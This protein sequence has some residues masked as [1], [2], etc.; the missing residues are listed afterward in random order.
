VVTEGHSAEALDR[1][2]YDMLSG[3]KVVEVSMWAFVPSAGAVL[4]D[5]GADVVKVVPVDLQDPMLGKGVVAD[6][7]APRIKVP[8]MWELMNRG[9][10][11]IGLDLAHPRGQEVLKKMV[12][13]AD[14]FML[15]LLPPAQQRFG[16]T[17]DDIRAVKPDIVYARG[18]GQ[19]PRGPQSDK[20][21]FDATSFWAGS[22][23][24]F[25]ASQVSDEFISLISPAFGDVL[26]GLSL[27]SGITAALVRRLRTG[28][29]AVVDVSLLAAGMFSVAPSIVASELF[30]IDTIPRVRHKAAPNPLMAAYATKDGR[31]IVLGG[32][33]T[34]LDWASV[35]HSLQAP[36]LADD[37]R[38]S[39]FERRTENRQ[40]CIASL[41]EVFASRTL[42]EWTKILEDYPAPWTV[43]KT[44]HEML[45]DEQVL[46]NGYITE[47]ET[48][49]GPLSLVPSPVQFDQTP[50]ELRAA[51]GHAEHTDQIL[52]ELG[53]SEADILELKVAN[54]VT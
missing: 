9:K 53:Y 2:S 4:A 26:S 36:H 8:F 35:C 48:A 30:D 45:T 11:C 18:T 27:A 32:M 20:G 28:Q 46:A 15:N 49:G 41:D 10:R 1:T 23:L 24:G 14:V 31:Y 16:V 42:E 21:G 33:R 39:R 5:W 6:L 50:I 25:T 43:V 19:G 47:V 12:A 29:G 7:P 17:V 52:E 44:P 13:Q 54:A 40:A 3:I 22:G 37:L 34:D 38:F 51:P